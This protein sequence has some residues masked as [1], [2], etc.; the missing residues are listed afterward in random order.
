[1]IRFLPMV[2]ALTTQEKDQE[3][4]RRRYFWAYDNADGGEG[5]NATATKLL[6]LPNG[7][8]MSVERREQMDAACADRPKISDHRPNQ[9]DTWKHRTRNQLMFQPTLDSSNDTCKVEQ[10]PEP[11]MLLEGAASTIE[12]RSGRSLITQQAEDAS[13]VAHGVEQG[14]K[15]ATSAHKAGKKPANR[16]LENSSSE[17]EPSEERRARADAKDNYMCTSDFVDESERQ[18][19]SSEDTSTEDQ[20][21]R[22]VDGP[23]TAPR[24]P[25][26]SR[27]SIVLKTNA[28][29]IQ[30]EATRFPVPKAKPRPA[31]AW[32]SPIESPNS[33]RGSVKELLAGET[34]GDTQEYAEVPMTPS[35][36]PV[37][38]K[39]LSEKSRK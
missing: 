2:F 5:H 28:K 27:T 33:A 37:R 35:R 18:Q 12:A 31:G 9:V 34:T 38:T 21:A 20:R 24:A 6:I 19:P 3:A 32:A 22:A 1:M 15:A 30:A 16:S 17:S 10:G 29:G 26:A 8:V 4:F 25:R 23:A 13:E 11:G 36:V 39:R 14:R 7:N